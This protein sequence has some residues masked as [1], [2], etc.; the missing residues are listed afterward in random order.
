MENNILKL[1]I[2]EVGE[3]L[4][5]SQNSIKIYGRN[6]ILSNKLFE[7]GYKLLEKPT[8]KNKFYTV[9]KIKKM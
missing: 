6:E 3:I 2:D 1:T 8:R 7:E 9:E 5:L 4:S